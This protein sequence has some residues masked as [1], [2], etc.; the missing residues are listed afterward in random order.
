MDNLAHTLAGAVLGEAGLKRRT[1]L[2][3]PT[4]LIGANLPDIDVVAVLFGRSEGLA[5]RRGWTHGILALVVLP[6]LLT[7]AM[8]I[9]DRWRRRRG[10]LEAARQASADPPGPTGIQTPTRTGSP[11]YHRSS[12][13]H[14]LVWGDPCAIV[15]ESPP[16]SMSRGAGLSPVRPGQLL[17]LAYVAVLSH[18]FLDWLNNYGMRWLMPFDG[19]WFYGDALFIVDPWLWLALLLGIAISRRSGRSR[20]SRVAVALASLYVGGMLVAG[21]YGKR[22]VERG[23]RNA[24]L[25]VEDVMVGPVPLNPNRRDVVMRSDGVYYRATLHWLPRPS[26][27]ISPEF[28]LTNLEHPAALNAASHPEVQRFMQ[29]SRYPF[30]VFMNYGDTYGLILDDARYSDGL[31]TSWAGI[32]V[33]LPVPRLPEREGPISPPP[34][35]TGTAGLQHGP[36]NGTIFGITASQE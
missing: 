5:F 29:W 21:L 12:S 17:L 23:V 33:E 11:P 7:G 9:W 16:Q 25:T 28:I 19:T 18:P 20:G 36:P 15:S 4:L 27:R 26:L 8:L 2:A 13:A 24:G 10:S 32:E 3:M 1:A 22:M 35:G 6:L 30:F 14:T 34:R 31:S